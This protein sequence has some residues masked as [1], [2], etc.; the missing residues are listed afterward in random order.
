MELGDETLVQRAQAGDGDAFACLLERHYDR[1]FRLS[2]AL[3][4]SKADAEDLAQDICAALPGKLAGFQGRS[5]VTTWLYRITVNAAHD[6]RRKQKTRHRAAA[7]WGETERLRR[8]EN[9]DKQREIAW[10]HDA[11]N[12]LTPEL[13]ETLA[14]VLG[15]ELTHAQAARAL[16]I[17]EG[18]VSWRM[19][20][21]KKR[22]RALARNEERIR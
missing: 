7:G 4:G 22:L 21:A 10:L 9:E 1:I 18:T 20:E 15:A 11:M 16:D 13:R 19:S 6:H 3:L 2:F 12:D 8:A 5:K 14:L 17:G